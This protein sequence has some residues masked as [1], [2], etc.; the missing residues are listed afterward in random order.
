MLIHG[1]VLFFSCGSTTDEK[2]FATGIDKNDGGVLSE[3]ACDNKD[4]DLGATTNDEDCFFIKPKINR[5]GTGKFFM[6]QTNLHS[7]YYIM[8]LACQFKILFVNIARST[9]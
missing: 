1:P 5:D 4:S 3:D 8:Y 6:P 9:P 2:S 7:L